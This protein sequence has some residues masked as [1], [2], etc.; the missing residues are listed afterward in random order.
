MFAYIAIEITGMLFH[1]MWRDEIHPWSMAGASSSI[2]DLLHRKA[3]EGHPDLW[4]ILIYM[5]RIVSDNPLSMQLMHSAIAILTV[6]L[7]LKYAPFTRI[8]R[9]LLVFGYFYLFEYAIIS[10]NYAIGLLLIT[11]ILILYRQRTKYLFLHALILFFL[12]QTNVYG[13]IFCIA[14]LM[15]WFFEFFFNTKLR[16]ELLSRKVTSLISLT[17]ILAGI[18]FSIYSIIPP[19]TG[20]FASVSH[21]EFSKITMDDIIRALSVAWKSW[22]PLPKLNLQFW[23]SNFIS[24]WDIKLPLSLFLM[25]SAGV[26]FIKRPVIFFLY[27]TGMS[28]IIAFILLYYHGYIRHQGHAY[29]LLISCLWLRGYYPE[30]NSRFRLSFLNRYHDWLQRNF[31]YLFLFMLAVQVL[32]AMYAV[33]VQFFVPFS[34]AKMT[35]GY[36]E[37]H[38]LNRFMIAG[39][40]DM[41]LEPVAGYLKKEVFFFSRNAFSTYLIYDNLR[42]LPERSSILV[43]ADSLLKAHNDT[44]LLV[45]NYP[46]LTDSFVNLK[47]IQSFEKSIR[48]DEIYYLYLL[49]PSKTIPKPLI[50]GKK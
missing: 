42:I 12:A 5:L 26:L 48:D 1:P 3:I 17:L 20:Y 46:L 41:A 25:F 7:V 37:Q 13:L 10:R 4:Y 40:Q 14:F 22:F 23:D 43:K 21:V 19:A 30:S 9:G 8:Q 15:T 27:I 29:I 16:D 33:T 47:E 34:A 45:M 6:F 39:D 2:W 11:L 50:T 28:G 38:K 24:E 36:I 35:A 32:A 44:I 18:A 31:R 49:T